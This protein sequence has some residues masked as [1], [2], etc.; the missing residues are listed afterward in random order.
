MVTSAKALDRKAILKAQ[1]FKPRV[2]DPYSGGTSPS[3]LFLSDH[4]VM[5]GTPWDIGRYSDAAARKPKTTPLKSALALGAKPHL[6]VAGG[7]L[8]PEIRR[9]M[10]TPYGARDMHALAPIAPLLQTEAGLTLDLDK[11]LD[12]TMQFNAPTEIAAGNALEAVKTLRTLGELALEKSQEA[13]EAGGW[14]LDFE[15]GLGKALAG[16]VFEK[17]GKTVTAHFK[18]DVTTRL[19]NHLVKD[20]VGNFRLKGDRTRSVNNLK[21]IGLAM[22]NYHD[23]NKR[24]PAAGIH[25][26]N[27]ANAK[28]LLSW[29]VAIL[30]YIEQGAL[31]NQFDLTQPWDHPTNKKL[32]DKMPAIYVVPGTENKRGET[33]YR[34]LVGRSAMFELTPGNRGHAL[35]SITDGTSNTIMV[36]EAAQ[37][38]IWTQPDDLPFDPNGPLPKFGT[39]PDGFNVLMG[40]GTVRFLRANT[41]QQTLRAM[42][43]RDGGEVVQFPDDR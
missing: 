23:V 28:P 38:T 15:R 11:T 43:T 34:V 1:L 6:V 27:D 30:P 9:M 8:A 32:I 18:M 19:V 25:A 33:N 13:G 42:I 20:F 2:H 12:L 41:P 17:K 36:V 14:K 7:Q 24:L 16:A 35:T 40:D 39:S 26:I 3:V 31:Y 4:T 21:Q 29:R 22:H 37:P 5:L 10:F